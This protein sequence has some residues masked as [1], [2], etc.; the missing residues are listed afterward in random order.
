MA[1]GT[2]AHAELSVAM[3]SL[4]LGA[5][6]D[7]KVFSSDLKVHIE[8]TGLSTFPDGTVVSDELRTAAFDRNAVTIPAIVIEVT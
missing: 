4:L 7:C 5:L 1:C 8:A 6:G 2:P 3:S